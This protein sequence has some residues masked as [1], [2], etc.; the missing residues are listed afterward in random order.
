MSFLQ[1]L[2]RLL[3]T[4]LVLALIVG[5]YFTRST[6]L[7]W[8]M[9]T[10]AG[11]AAASQHEA[12]PVTDKVLLSDQA[13]TNLGIKSL[14]L[15]TSAYWKSITVPGMVVDRPGQSDR[16]VVSPV[17][18]VIQTVHRFPGESVAP[19]EPLF[20]IRVLSETLHKAQSELFK[21]AQGIKL[22]Q[23]QKA[24]LAQAGNAI[25]ESRI[26]EIDQQLARLDIS[27]RAARAELGT[28]GFTPEQIEGITEGK[29]V[30]EIEI[31]VPPLGAAS[32]APAS[33]QKW[34]EVQELKAE[35]G[36]Q[37]QAG[38]TLCMLANHRILAIEG[39]AFRDETPF[40]ER[41]VKESWPVEVDFQEP[42]GSGW[43]PSKQIFHIQHLANTIDPVNRTFAFRIPLEN[44]SKVIQQGTTSQTFWRYRP[45]Q[46]VRIQVP[47]EKWDNVFV[48]PRDAIAKDGLESI[49]FTQN[50]NTFLRRPVKVLLQ[51]RQTV[52]IAYDATF[53][54]GLFVAQS[55]AAQLQR[56]M[57]SQTSGAPPGYHMHADGS[58]HKNGEDEK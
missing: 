38:Q 44:E 12:A 48:L 43:V 42:D 22:A 32:N 24:R 41:A 11:D 36:Q 50:V 8:V 28:R 53:P 15:V 47:I 45:G 1:L 19:G 10:K 20:T 13:I 51:D 17:M 54:A 27:A 49:L 5:G 21:T 58:I 52:V 46:K 9:T 35:L 57:K 31:V 23:A 37:V 2:K 33:T 55:G 18:G 25:P 14:P 7:P 4:V 29:F 39:R 6:W 56:M 3:P 16:G 30:K 40:L 34:Y 26:L